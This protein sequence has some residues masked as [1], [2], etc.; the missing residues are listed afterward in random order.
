MAVLAYIGFGAN[1]GDREATYKNALRGLS[2]ISGITVLK[3]SKLYETEPVNLSDNGPRFLNAAI[4]IVTEL[5]PNELASTMREV[6]L[7][8]GKSP[9]HRSD[10]SRVVDLD[11]LLYGDEIVRDE[12]LIVPHPRMH[13]R[14]FVLAPLA[15]IAPDVTH[16]RLELTVRELADALPENAIGL[17]TVSES[18]MN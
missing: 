4:Q 2:D 17:K 8:L 3:S 1:L 16:P 9:E 10:L 15:E 11:L 7:S 12:G 18:N 6:E 13:E 5:S 14:E